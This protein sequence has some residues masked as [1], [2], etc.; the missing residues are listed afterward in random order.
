M[1]R[2]VIEVKPSKGGGWQAKIREN[3]KFV[4]VNNN[5][6]KVISVA[7]QTARD[8]GHSRLI[9]KKANGHIQTESTYE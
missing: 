7:R 2:S 6:A 3:G 5:K 8:L 9:I 4:I 1:K